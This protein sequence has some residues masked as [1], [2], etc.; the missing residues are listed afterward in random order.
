MQMWCVPEACLIDRVGHVCKGVNPGEDEHCNTQHNSVASHLDYAHAWHMSTHIRKKSCAANI[1]MEAT[2]QK[3]RKAACIP[4]R[5]K[6]NKHKGRMILTYVTKEAVECEIVIK[7]H[8][9]FQE[10]CFP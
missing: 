5:A 9:T 3:S 7:R 8:N 10:G 6:G 2:L 1:G 4:F